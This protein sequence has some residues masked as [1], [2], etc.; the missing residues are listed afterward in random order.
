MAVPRPDRFDLYEAVRAQGSN[1]EPVPVGQVDH[2][3]GMGSKLA[4][5]VARPVANKKRPGR[6]AGPFKTRQPN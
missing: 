5:D 2:L 6:L 1:P 3:I 4:P